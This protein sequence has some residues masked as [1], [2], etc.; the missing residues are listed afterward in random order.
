MRLNLEYLT[1]WPSNEQ[2]PST[3]RMGYLEVVWG[4]G[5]GEVDDRQVHG[6]H[7]QHQVV[8][9]PPLDLGHGELCKLIIEHS[10]GVEAVAV[11]WRCPAR[12]ACPLVG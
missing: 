8:N 12:P 3:E 2:T 1:Y 9:G 7:H 5:E 6:L 4:C 10:R 11:P